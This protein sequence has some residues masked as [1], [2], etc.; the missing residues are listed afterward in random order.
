MAYY[1]IDSPSSW[2][3]IIWV[4]M[5][6]ILLSLS[7]LIWMTLIIAIVAELEGVGHVILSG[8]VLTIIPVTAGIYFVRR[9]KSRHKKRIF[10]M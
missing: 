4:W 9:G 6:I 7:A 1:R 5:G 10:Y 2:K 3:R 8:L